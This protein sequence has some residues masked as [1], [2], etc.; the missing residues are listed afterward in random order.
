MNQHSIRKNL[1]LDSYLG[2]SGR[3]DLAPVNDRPH[4]DVNRKTKDCLKELR[5]TMRTLLPK[6]HSIEQSR[7]P[8]R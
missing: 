7:P 8:E 5:D 3:S 1:W 6:P 2:N 4:Q